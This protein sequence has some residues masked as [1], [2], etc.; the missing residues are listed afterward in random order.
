M[1]Y[2]PSAFV[3]TGALG[4][5]YGTAYLNVPIL[6]LY[7]YD[8]LGSCCDAW[9]DLCEGTTTTTTSTTTTS[10][11][12]TT[13]PDERRYYPKAFVVTG[14]LGCE[15][16]LAYKT[17]SSLSSFH[18]ATLEECCGEWEDLCVE[19][20]DLGEGAAADEMPLGDEM[21]PVVG[22]ELFSEYEAPLGDEMP[23]DYET[24]T[25]PVTDASA[26]FYLFAECS[27]DADCD[28]V[29]LVC[30]SGGGVCLR[31]GGETCETGHDRDQC[32]TDFVC[33]EGNSWCDSAHCRGTCTCETDAACPDGTVCAAPGCGL[34]ADIARTCIAPS[35][36]DRECHAFFGGETTT[37]FCS[38]GS[39]AVT[40]L[41]H[42]CSEAVLVDTE[43][44]TPSPAGSSALAVGRLAYYYPSFNKERGTVVCKHGSDYPDNYLDSPDKYLFEDAVDCYDRWAF[45][46]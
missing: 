26:D 12:T 36:L 33:Y 27:S 40:G 8:T 22:D 45:R 32:A 23:L 29:G 31:T 30:D 4:C 7:S 44:P 16:G 2:Y 38:R 41:H 13:T 37:S 6:A 43:A 5:D 11:T 1:K 3:E 19:G 34:I 21:P 10:T 15:H 17:L 28:S 14:E 39:S 18:Y 20:D 46:R 24:D 35:E 25:P 9:S 42:S